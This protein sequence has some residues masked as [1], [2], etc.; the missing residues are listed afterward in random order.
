MV[1]LDNLPDK[2][3]GLR[4]NQYGNH[5]AERKAIDKRVEN[6]R[7]VNSFLIRVGTRSSKVL[8]LRWRAMASAKAA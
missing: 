7:V 3:F 6:A 1:A 2:V 5:A 8:D 4:V